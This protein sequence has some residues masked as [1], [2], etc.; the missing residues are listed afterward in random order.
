[1]SALAVPTLVPDA[2]AG[3]KLHLALQLLHVGTT[4]PAAIADTTSAPSSDHLA[5]HV[6]QLVLDAI[7]AGDAT[8]DTPRDVRWRERLYELWRLP[9]AQLQEMLALRGLDYE[10]AEP[11]SGP[12]V[13]VVDSSHEGDEMLTDSSSSGHATLVYRM[14]E[15]EQEL[16]TFDDD[17][18]E[19]EFDDNMFRTA[20]GDT[21]GTWQL[22]SGGGSDAA[23]LADFEALVGVVRGQ[24]AVP[25]KLSEAVRLLQVRSQPPPP[26]QALLCAA[27]RLLYG[28]HTRPLET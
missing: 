22:S 27:S 7:A 9:S 28:R 15:Y 10:L 11:Q 26:P 3:C 12:D 25:A 20:G 8:D 17:E 13:P 1:M 2:A 5:A 21:G 14:L 18:D 16:A 6:E 4:Q 23:A 19:D 24:L